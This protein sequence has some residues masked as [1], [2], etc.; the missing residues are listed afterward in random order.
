[1]N[2]ENDILVSK[3]QLSF[4]NLLRD[5]LPKDLL[6]KAS[7]SKTFRIL[8]ICC[9]RFRE[10]KPIF[11]YFSKF[12]DKLKLYCIDLDASFIDLA[13]NE[14]IIKENKNSVYLRTGDASLIENYEDW[15]KDGLFD[16][17]IVRHPEI[18]FNTD[19]FIKIF[20]LC[21]QLINKNG[22]LLITTHFENEKESLQILLKLINFKL[23]TSIEN[24]NA[25][26]IKKNNDTCYV[27]RFL[28]LS[29][30]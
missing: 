2:T 3:I 17:V 29:S 21:P 7:N 14:P 19:I 24:K 30:I 12:K 18:T 6:D 4:L 27:D 15:L 26:V 1:M 20:S 5:Y 9:G 16:L 8:S 10:A 13:S 11:E 25:P 22:L 28:L 23:L